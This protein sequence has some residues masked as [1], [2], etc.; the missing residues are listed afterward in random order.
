[1]HF[2]ARVAVVLVFAQGVARAEGAEFIDYRQHIMKT[3]GEQAQ[4]L[5]MIVQQKAPAENLQLHVEALAMA[6]TQALKAFEPQVEGGNSKPEVWAQWPDFSTRMRQ[7][8]EGIAQLQ[9]LGKAGNRSA[10][11]SKMS[12]L[13]ACDGCHG[14]YLESPLSPAVRTTGE[15][16]AVEYREHVMT[17]LD[18]QSAALGQI[19]STEIPPANL[20]SHLQA[21]ALIGASSKKAFEPKVPGGQA[22]PEVWSRWPD[23]SRR[24]DEFAQK[25]AQAAALA[26]AQGA[27]AALPG[28]MDA[29]TC[30]VCH[31]I[32]RTKK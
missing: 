4:A 2:A 16:S 6:S 28:I 19:L 10:M 14:A 26:S 31:E 1:M 25:T 13:L 24:M 8:V 27:D 5:A 9:K 15:P 18:A 3:L 7:M 30:K 11:A 12:A 17:S 22:K 29:L 20:T 32:Y 23:F 21:I